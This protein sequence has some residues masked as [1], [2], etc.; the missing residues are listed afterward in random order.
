MRRVPLAVRA[1]KRPLKKAEREAREDRIVAAIN[2]GVH[3][4]DICARFRI[5][6]HELR[7]IRRRHGLDV[8]KRERRA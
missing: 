8:Q 4:R 2:A 5:S 3:M 6:H 1:D 7:E